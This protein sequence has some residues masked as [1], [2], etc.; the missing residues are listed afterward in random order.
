MMLDTPINKAGR[1]FSLYSKKLE[2]L[3]ITTLGDLLLH[4]P[5]RYEDYTTITPIADAQ[6]GQ[7]VTIVGTVIS[8]QNVYTRSRF[9]IQKVT[10]ADK[11]GEIECVWFNQS[12]I[13][14]TLHVGD[15]VSAAG[16]VER[17]GP[18]TTFQVKEYEVIAHPDADTTHTGRLVSIYPETRGV[19]SR[20]MRNRIKTILAQIDE[21]FPEHLP[22]DLREKN[23]LI[24]LS[25]A[26]R[27]IHFPTTFDEATSARTR[28]AYDELFLIQLGAIHRK[29]EWKIKKTTTPFTVT[30]WKKELKKLYTSLPFTLTD[31]QNRAVQE[32]LSDVSQNT[33]MNRLL[34]GDVGSGKT[35]VAAIGM[36]LAKLNGFQSALM[37]PTEILAT[38]HYETIS[39]ILE[40]LDVKIELVTGS[41]KSKKSK[42]KN[43]N[44][45]SAPDIIIGTHA[46]IHKGVDF[47]KLGFVVVDEQH[48]FGVQQRSVL[49]DKGATPHFLSMTATPIPRTVFLTMYGDLE[50]SV[51]DELPK[52]RQKIKTWLVPNHKRAA[53]YAW[54]EKMVQEKDKQGNTNQVFIV[55]PF[56]EE[57][58]SMQTVRAATKE[59]EK[60]QKEIF[61]D[62]KLGLLHGKMKATEKQAVLDNFQKGKL[63]ILVSTPVVEVG[64]DIPNATIIM[65]EAAERFGL[66][67]LHQLRG[68]VGRNDKQSY[69]L[70]FTESESE[71][72]TQRLKSL[73]T[74]HSGS[75]LA[76]IDLKRRGAGDMYGTQQHGSRMLKV[77]SFGDS[78]LIHLTQQD[79]HKIYKKLPKYPIL[80][81]KLKS[82]IIH[83]RV[84]PD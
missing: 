5:S 20:W 30:P 73:E 74:T 65:I 49:R 38:Q 67:S 60:L 33:P 45:P 37:A 41:S 77:A 26:I 39:Q 53:G 72:T 42:A 15:L 34:Q 69:C 48:R 3:A 23:N 57:S 64:I 55:C 31:A 24:S 47:E 59:Y 62:L 18:K 40:P 56:I 27:K 19:T 12:Y 17:T 66:A 58:E 54:I 76:E 43:T 70:L 79:A 9:Q 63:D 78:T 8:T 51:L 44:N 22:L 82:T 28:L 81:E 29:H 4:L 68:R 10:L 32:L 61:P 1:A 2:K 80:H 84:N 83:T 16:R 7:V 75:A 14:R 13:L 46:L 25:D 71:K 11:T 52:G 21:L 36:Y 6:N 50:L 35:I